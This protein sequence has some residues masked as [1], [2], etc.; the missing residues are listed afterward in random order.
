MRTGRAEELGSGAGRPLGGEVLEQLAR[1]A[2]CG[3]V[4]D[5][6]LPGAVDL[7]VV[8]PR[9]T[10]ADRRTRRTSGLWFR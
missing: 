1:P 7:G 3:G 5:D 2:D 10:A 6:V 4:A 9:R 8:R